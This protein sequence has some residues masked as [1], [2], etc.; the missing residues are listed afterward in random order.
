[1]DMSTIK[2]GKAEILI[3]QTRRDYPVEFYIQSS[4]SQATKAQQS[5][6]NDGDG[7]FYL[8][9]I[10]K[11]PSTSIRSQRNSGLP[12]GGKASEVGGCLWV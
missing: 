9:A 6:P 5:K 10:N 3:N 1:M 7:G 4:R 2:F 8:P 11:S 12:N